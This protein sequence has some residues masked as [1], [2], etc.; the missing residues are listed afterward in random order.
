MSSA[1]CWTQRLLDSRMVTMSSWTQHPRDPLD[2]LPLPQNQ[3]MRFQLFESSQG[4]TVFVASS[5]HAGGAGGQVSGNGWDPW[6]KGSFLVTVSA[7][8]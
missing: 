4:L 7:N 5:R 2:P 3:D 1:T 6:W 8:T